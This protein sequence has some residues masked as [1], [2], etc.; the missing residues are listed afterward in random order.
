M[1]QENSSMTDET[2]LKSLYV[3]KGKMYSMRKQ[4]PEWEKMET[5]KELK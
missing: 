1:L 4:L 2:K 3:V 5:N